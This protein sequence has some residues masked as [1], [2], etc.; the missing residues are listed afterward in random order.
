MAREVRISARCANVSWRD[1][2]EKAMVTTSENLIILVL[3]AAIAVLIGVLLGVGLSGVFEF[4]ERKRS[5]GGLNRELFRVWRGSVAQSLNLEIN[6]KVYADVE[7]LSVGEFRELLGYIRELLAWLG[8][9]SGDM[10][11]EMPDSA[12][13]AILGDRAGTEIAMETDQSVLPG[14]EVYS[15][16][17]SIAIGESSASEPPLGSLQQEE[18]DRDKVKPVGIFRTMLGFG[19][20]KKTTEVVPPMSLSEQINEI[21]QEKLG[22]AN[23]DDR[24]IYILE[25]PE[26][27]VVV[28]IGEDEYEGVEQVPDEQIKTLIQESVGEWESR[29]GNN[30][31]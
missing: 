26:R 24:K 7:P 1:N 15:P 27:G 28:V 3:V 11:A 6:G 20:K 17:S 18:T 4:W 8:I 30:P 14:D 21:L 2:S 31:W 10:L 25:E 13:A 5:E 9:R 19:V 29:S 22:A 16:T 23:L 12:Q